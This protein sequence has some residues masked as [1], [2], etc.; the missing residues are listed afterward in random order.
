[1]VPVSSSVHTLC[2]RLLIIDLIENRGTLPTAINYTA[3]TEDVQRAAVVRL[4]KKY[5]LASRYTSFVAVYEKTDVLRYP[6]SDNQIIRPRQDLVFPRILLRPLLPFWTRLAR[7][8]RPV[9]NTAGVTNIDP[10]KRSLAMM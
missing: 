4:A 2:A 5:Q 10:S 7:R 3:N 8:T 1:V 9:D 6:S